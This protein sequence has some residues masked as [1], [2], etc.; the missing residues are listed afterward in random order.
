MAD[1]WSVL[2]SLFLSPCFKDKRRRER[3]ILQS[4]ILDGLQDAET[5]NSLLRRNG[6]LRDMRLG[7]VVDTNN[8]KNHPQRGDRD[9][10]RG[11]GLSIAQ[12]KLPLSARISRGL[13]APLGA[14]RSICTLCGFHY[15]IARLCETSYTLPPQIHR[16]GSS[17]ER[18]GTALDHWFELRL[19]HISW[20]D[21][22]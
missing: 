12:S 7:S 17:Y 5:I 11:P 20:D 15:S 9:D 19:V 21:Q 3:E 16:L 6:I 10:I 4:R 2:D 18:S 22:Q 1:N 14:S 13:D 8:A